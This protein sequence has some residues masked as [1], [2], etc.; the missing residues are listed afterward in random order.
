MKRL[1]KNMIFS[2]RLAHKLFRTSKDFKTMPELL[3][4][5]AGRVKH[6]KQHLLPIRYINYTQMTHSCLWAN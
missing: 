4:W 1:L 3:I 2:I 5:E 6:Y